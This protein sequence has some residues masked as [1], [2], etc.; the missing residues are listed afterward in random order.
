[1]SDILHESFGVFHERKSE[2]EIFFVL[3]NKNTGAVNDETKILR[4]T[5]F[6]LLYNAI[7]ATISQI[8]REYH[9]HLS[10][11]KFSE[12][13][14]K[15]KTHYIDLKL[16][17]CKPRTTNYETYISKSKEIIKS[18]VDEAAVD[19]KINQLE[20]RLPMSGN[21]DNEYIAKL[22]KGEW[23]MSFDD[24]K[25]PSSISEI[26]KKRNE[27]SHGRMS[28]MEVGKDLTLEDL[29]RHKTEVLTCLETL[30]EMTKK[31]TEA[32]YA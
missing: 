28:F 30:L 11:K 10:S 17:D 2:V 19:F 23:G 14:E 25:I 5:V 7:E 31:H 1:M 29:R 27:L 21:I 3:L 22:F 12:L 13:S 26:K 18:I 4:A 6:L 9:L 15:L 32:L 16:S 20:D 24:F 8:I